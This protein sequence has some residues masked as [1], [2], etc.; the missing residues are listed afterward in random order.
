MDKASD[1][2][3]RLLSRPDATVL[4]AVAVRMIQ[5]L[6]AKLAAFERAMAEISSQCHNLPMSV[7]ASRIDDLAKSVSS[8]V[9]EQ[10]GTAK[11]VGEV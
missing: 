2:C 1:L 7:T 9:V 11:S 3:D 4:D 5:H 8:P 10:S 6:S